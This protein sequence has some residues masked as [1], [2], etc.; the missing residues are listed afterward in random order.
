MHIYK[1]IHTV[2]RE[3]VDAAERNGLARPA[4]YRLK[5]TSQKI[6]TLVEGIKSIAL[7]EEP[8]GRLTDRTELADG[9]V[10]DKITSPIGV[11][12]IIFESRPD[13]L[14]QVSFIICVLTVLMMPLAG[15]HFCVGSDFVTPSL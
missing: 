11:L 3:D 12:L 8:I 13:C 2:N 4:L 14:P 15:L 6:K 5:L 10:L 1:H 7:Q 9:L